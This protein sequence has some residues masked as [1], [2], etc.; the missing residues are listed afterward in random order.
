MRGEGESLDND[1]GG[2][3]DNE[4]AEKRQE[5]ETVDEFLESVYFDPLHA[6][7]YSGL[8][9]LWQAVKADN[10]HKLK[11]KQ[12]KEW[13]EN[14][15]SYLRHTRLEEKF[16]RQKI[17][18]SHVDEQWD[19]DLMD[20]FKFSRK[21]KGYKYLAIFID[22]FSRYLWVEPMKTKTPV[23][24]VLVLKRVFSQGRKPQ[25]MRTD[26]GSEYM[27]TAVQQYLDMKRVHHFVAFNAIHANY[28]ERV[29]RTLKGKIYRYM[30]KNQTQ[31]YID[32]LDDFVDSYLDTVHRGTAMRPIDIKKENEQEI[33][34]KLYLPMQLADEKKKIDFKFKVD[35]KVHIA[36]NRT[37]FTKG[38]VPTLKKEVF[39]IK[40]R[41]H[42][43]PPRY[44]LVDLKGRDIA[45]TVYEQEIRK[46]TYNKGVYRVE[47]VVR[48]RTRDKVKEALIRWQGYGEDFDSWIPDADVAKYK[49]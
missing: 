23:E 18:M 33:Y 2:T 24:M 16:P 11:F 25:F 44:K 45:G 46:V 49:A 28:A 17:I 39:K 31:V 41:T 12:V 47:K 15:E 5:E 29:I 30:M 3:F 43:I 48:R 22:I 7:S 20:M 27:G 38:Y 10:P 19:A 21:N 8:V 35:D 40:Y 4:L 14:Q 9:K 26:K 1:Q 34:E 6:G 37:K 13:L 36:A 32:H 42:T